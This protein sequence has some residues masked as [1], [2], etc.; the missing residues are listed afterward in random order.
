[1]L[2][3]SV[4]MGVMAHSLV[5]CYQGFLEMYCPISELEGSLESQCHENIANE[6]QQTS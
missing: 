1:M 5:H 2:K 4:F 6:K 3:I